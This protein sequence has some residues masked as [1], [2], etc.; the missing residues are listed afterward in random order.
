MID[1]VF[2]DTPSYTLASLS[3][4]VGADVTL[5]DERLTPIG[6][7]KGRGAEVIVQSYPKGTDFICASA[8]NFGQGMAWAARRHS[9][10]LTV[11]AATTAVGCKI[12]RMRALGAR[13]LLHGQDFDEA[14]I[15]AREVASKAGVVFIEDGAHAEIAE[16]AGTLALELTDAFDPFDAIF[17]PLG[18]G[19]LAAGVGC[20]MKFRTPET[21]VVAVCAELS[22][23]M[24][25]AVLGRSV[26]TVPSSHTIADG[27]AVRVPV[28]AA[29]EAVRNVVDQVVFVDDESI[30]KAMAL[31]EEA[32]G[33]RVE[34]A[35]AVGL[36]ALLTQRARWSGA[37]VVVP[38]CGGNR[39]D[40]FVY[41]RE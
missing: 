29:V 30:L 11:Y 14:K 9:S 24:G 16:G 21:R 26:G 23:A 18:N 8:G 6:S 10:Q 39:D 27:I 5:K 4:A 7:F 37:R 13:V 19:A 15:E 34:P 38:L 1:P 32:T 31:V 35:G 36:A 28:P 33:R 40:S 17:V 25:L 2:L 22:P 12:D 20:W 41:S 3:K